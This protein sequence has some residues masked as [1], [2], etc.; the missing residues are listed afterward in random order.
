[1]KEGVEYYLQLKDLASGNLQ[2][3]NLKLMKTDELVGKTNKSTKEL[4]HGFFKMAGAAYIANQAMGFVTNSAREM[5]GLTADFQ[6]YNAVLTNTFGSGRMAGEAMAMILDIAK[7]TP[8]SV[9][10]LTQSYVKLAN[11][12]ITPTRN[13]IIALGD[14]AASTGLSF[15]QLAEAIMDASNPERWKEF[16]V[17]T[18]RANGMVTL[19]FK[20]VSKTVKDNAG[21]VK[22]AIAEFGRMNGVMGNMAAQSNVLGGRISNLGDTWDQ[23]LIG[24]G[25]GN[26]NVMTAT[27]DLLSDMIKGSSELLGIVPMNI[28]VIEDEQRA[29]VAMNDALKDP[30]KPEK[31]KLAIMEKLIKT[32]PELLDNMKAEYGQMF[33]M[34]IELDRMVTGLEKKIAFQKLD[35]QKSDQEKELADAQGRLSM[36]SAEIGMRLPEFFKNNP[37]FKGIYDKKY[38]GKPALAF[39]QAL[40]AS[41]SIRGGKIGANAD[42]DLVKLQQGGTLGDLI[43][44]GSSGGRV[45]LNALLGKSLKDV[46]NTSNPKSINREIIQLKNNISALTFQRQQAESEFNKFGFETADPTK[47]TLTPGGSGTGKDGALENTLTASSPKVVNINIDA[48]QRGNMIFNEAVNLKDI[49]LIVR[50]E[51]AQALAEAVANSKIIGGRQF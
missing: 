44:G 51:I 12:G 48:V 38:S 24:L 46:V 33:Q 1:M 50:S 16:G 36:M 3:F 5:V 6:K 4:G 8:F 14:F 49:K 13:E 29:L 19:T 45:N 9:N 35:N 42:P 21:A 37:Q 20:G 18:S 17:K 30:N 39:W 32:Y 43:S 31:E 2:K 26:N 34:N 47:I 40:Q 28:R 23:F 15:D 25:Q 7:T 41:Q 11:R 27:V 22:Q 10:E